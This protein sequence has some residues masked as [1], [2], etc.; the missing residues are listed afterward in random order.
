MASRN[1][2]GYGLMRKDSKTS[3]VGAHRI[4]WELHYGPIPKGV[5]VLHHCDNPA[6]VNPIHLFLG[7]HLSNMVDMAQKG[8][9]GINGRNY[10]GETNPRAKLT[11]E[12]VQEIRTLPL[13]QRKLDYKFGVSPWEIQNILRNR[14]WKHDDCAP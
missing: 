2:D 7:T 4:S 14:S 12:Q 8:R 5:D 9:W 10:T 1:G 6:C 13:S 3:M 11:A